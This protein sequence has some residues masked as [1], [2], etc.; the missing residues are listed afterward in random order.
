M[1]FINSVITAELIDAVLEG[2]AGRMRGIHGMRHWQAV[3]KNA[4]YLANH[5]GADS[6]VA[7][8][9]ALLHDARREN[10]DSDPGHG[11]RAAELA[12]ELF[13]Q[14]ALPID[15]QQL[16]WL[17]E[18]CRDHTHVTFTDNPTIAC[19]WDADRLDLVRL[20]ILPDPARLNTAEARHIARR[21]KQGTWDTNNLDIGR[22]ISDMIL[23]R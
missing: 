5:C 9:F 2:K 3:E 6:T 8:L 12:E 21:L 10:D 20:E 1:N 16:A 4:L 17:K 11:P 19:C 15:G 14:G 23:S 22:G 18:A 13:R 7:S